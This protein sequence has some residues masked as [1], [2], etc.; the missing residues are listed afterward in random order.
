[1]KTDFWKNSILEWEKSRYDG[2][3]SPWIYSSL[4]ARFQKLVEVVESLPK[5]SKVLE[6]GCGSGRLFEQ[7]KN[8]EDIEYIGVD[9]SAEAISL[10][11]QKNA[12]HNNAIWICASVEEIQGLQIDYIVSIGLMDWISDAQFEKFL[13]QNQTR[14]QF[15]SFS[16]D[17]KGFRALLHRQFTKL[18]RL[19]K[20]SNYSPQYFT[21]ENILR[22]FQNYND[23]RIWS[24]PSLSFGA[25]IHNLDFQPNKS[26]NT[27]A[28]YFGRKKRDRNPIESFFK[29]HELKQLQK[30]NLTLYKKNVLEVGSG[31]GFYTNY[32]LQQEPTRLVAVDPFVDTRKFVS[33]PSFDFF[34]SL[35]T[36]PSIQFDSIFCIGV[37]EFLERPQDLWTQIESFLNDQSEVLVVFPKHRTL[38]YFCY[39]VYHRFKSKIRLTPVTPQLFLSQAGAN[40]KFHVQNYGWLNVLVRIQKATT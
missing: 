25:F 20:N 3:L 26:L 7:I 35:Q 4:Q 6:I 12:S 9:F 32:F 37:C 11:Q 24:H 8:R 19:K 22:R 30:L 27:V 40:H 14:F 23:F 33:S 21:D 10:A 31:D 1:M 36:L 16:S 34:S 2:R 18:I 39:Q 15:H 17:R 13:K 38:F 28:R 5:G 29:R